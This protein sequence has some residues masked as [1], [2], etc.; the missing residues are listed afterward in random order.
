MK[1][2]SKH[3]TDE[4]APRATAAV[5]AARIST[6]SGAAV[7]A[8]VVGLLT[9]SVLRAQDEP[10]LPFG[11]WESI[12]DPNF[13]YDPDHS[14]VATFAVQTTARVRVLFESARDAMRRGEYRVACDSLQELITLYP[15]H[16]YQVAND[17]PRYVGAAEYAK[18]LIASFPAEGRAA[19][20]EFA[21]LRSES[22]WRA[23]AET[24]DPSKLI[25][26]VRFW[27]L[28]PEGQRALDRLGRLALERGDFEASERFYGRKLAFESVSSTAE[29]ASGDAFLAAASAA[30]GRSDSPASRWIERFGDPSVTVSGSPAKARGILPE[31]GSM[32]PP[33]DAAWPVV[34]GN[35]AHDGL[36]QFDPEALTFASRWTTDSFSGDENPWRRVRE[37]RESS[38]FHPVVASDVI[39]LCDGLSIRAWSF[40]SAT[41]KW[42]YIGPLSGSVAPQLYDFNSLLWDSPMPGMDND[43]GTLAR[44][45]PLVATISDHVVLGALLEPAPHGRDVE[46]DQ[47]RI[48]QTVPRR[49]LY[50]VDVEN[51]RLLW[52]MRRDDRPLHDFINRVSILSAPV[53]VGDRIYVTG[54]LLEGAINVYAMCLSLQD[55]SLL[56]KTPLVIGQQELTMFNK[57]F[58]EFTTQM[59]AE[60][61]GS[62]FL[63]TNLGLSGCLDGLTGNPRWLAQYE[64]IPIK[65]TRHYRRTFE[66]PR[67]W[68]NDPAIVREGVC[69]VTPL[70]SDSAYAY[71]ASTGKI[72]WSVECNQDKNHPFDYCTV[73]G[74]D[75]GA[76]IFSGPSGIGF[77][78]LRNG[79]L[80]G[81]YRFRQARSYAG[82]GCLGDGVLFQPLAEGLLELRY[83]RTKAGMDLRDRTLD[84]GFSDS[85]GLPG[86]LLVHRDFQIV[87][88]ASQMTVFYD[89]ENLIQR[90]ETR[91]GSGKGTLADHVDLGELLALRGN[92]ERAITEFEGVLAD[93]SISSP[94]T[95]ASLVRRAHE[96]LAVA[97]HQLAERADKSGL[98]A[99]AAQ[100][101]FA[102][103]EHSLDDADF[104]RACEQLIHSLE[105]ADPS[106][107]PA[108]LDWI[109]ERC[110]NA[111]Y[112]FAA[113]AYGTPIPAGLYTLDRRAV[114]ALGRRDAKAA[115]SS[116][117]RIIDLYRDTPFPGGTAGKHAERLIADAIAKYGRSIYAE[118]DAA[119]SDARSAASA[120]RNAAALLE[121]VMRFPNAAAAPRARLDLAMI[122]LERKEYSEVFRVVAPLLTSAND[123][124]D[125]QNAL[126]LAARGA[127]LAGDSALARLMLKRIVATG[128]AAASV[129]EPASDVR[130]V[131]TRDL[132]ALGAEPAAVA[133]RA[134]LERLPD[135]AAKTLELQV[136][137]S[138]L[139]PVEFDSEDAILVYEE[140]QLGAPDAVLRRID[141]A[142]L[143]EIWHVRVPAYASDL[144]PLRAFSI[145]DRI[146]FR[147]RDRLFGIDK[148]S[149]ITRFDTSLAGS[150]GASVGAVDSAGSL[151]F[152][153]LTPPTQGASMI[154][155][156]ETA[157]GMVL[158][159]TPL[160]FECL[161]IQAVRDAVLAIGASE[162]PTVVSLDALTG[163]KRFAI[164]NLAMNKR[165]EAR[166]YEEFGVVLT[167]GRENAE[168][169]SLASFDLEDGRPLAYVKEVPFPMSFEWLV[170]T[171][172]GFLLPKGT[173]PTY[174]RS[175]RGIVSVSRLEPRTGTVEQC[176]MGLENLRAFD[177]GSGTSKR[178]FVLVGAG[179]GSGAAKR[180]RLV[181]IDLDKKAIER[182][183]DMTALPPG[184]PTFRASLTRTGDVY[185]L[186]EIRR[187]SGNPRRTYLF[188]FAPDAGTFAAVE[189]PLTSE[190]A[191]VQS[192][193]TPR[194]FAVLSGTALAVYE[195][196]K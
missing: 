70:D 47:T 30:F 46:F 65:A 176:V 41:P 78:D 182:T 169:K 125:R 101:R 23:I 110:P 190:R 40:Y 164:S 32:M 177:T 118:F 150:S 129:V 13:K 21:R 98:A 91:I 85:A 166:A 184:S 100:H 137:R 31:F 158:W 188:T 168:T 148:K 24:Q 55:G 159:S 74:V 29:K 189:I 22:L 193:A 89:L 154:V 155:A 131:A 161:E 10:F 115:V 143:S 126:L 57:P 179:T 141:L 64:A 86:N 136:T 108:V 45:L 84:W 68:I 120:S 8:V 183:V 173:S 130:S 140:E 35:G 27:E 135:P 73:L 76:V 132:E 69:I 83:Q 152:A 94:A 17:P 92:V 138:V 105:A 186:A 90:V 81:A 178:R 97:H 36:V 107:I 196:S 102:E 175:P 75:Q 145:G 147:Q 170:P 180:D 16:V 38:P 192:V 171:T 149:G 167:L 59:V 95:D 9:T 7:A 88:S 109:D 114:Y 106:R 39:V 79:R 123:D 104:L 139:V 153:L 4:G 14:A 12:Q 33:R 50:A 187:A 61:D 19:Y 71:E 142:T 63:S 25:E 160:D 165:F 54:S 121:I 82:R 20:T 80:L 87:V 156:V 6:A 15:T 144:D 67:F 34:G 49:G 112:A 117:Q 3:R 162:Q 157:T 42:K 174:T 66:R 26:F 72:L 56:W 51:G 151:I 181:V 18:Y 5:P 43:F 2:A 1:L 127:A 185:G 37:I 191:P 53:A 77:H 116:W 58:K 111:Q 133:E 11:G 113:N 93:P 124:G 62:I 52:R 99:V 119:A 103:A 128:S 44:S 134:R 172:N 48:T 163:V 146:V 194:H 60:K 96:R 28:T 122:R 195:T